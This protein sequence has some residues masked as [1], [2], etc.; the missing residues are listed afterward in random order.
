ML[1]LLIDNI[2]MIIILVICIFDGYVIDKHH[3]KFISR[4]IFGIDLL[5]FFIWNVR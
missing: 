3:R 4:D 1:G 5:F 2:V